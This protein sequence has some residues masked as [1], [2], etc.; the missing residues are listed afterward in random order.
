MPP[1]EWAEYRND[2]NLVVALDHYASR[3]RRDWVKLTQLSAEVVRLRAMLRVCLVQQR[4][5]IIDPDLLNDAYYGD[6]DDG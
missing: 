6:D 3:C 5:P 2:P 4:E 1:M